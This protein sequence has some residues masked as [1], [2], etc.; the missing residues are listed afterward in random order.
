MTIVAPEQL[1]VASLNATFETAHPEKIVEWAASHF[2]DELVMSSSFGEQAAVLLHMATRLKPDIRIIFVDTGYLFPETYAFM[3]ALRH[4]FNLNVW[5][6]RT[7]NDPIVWLSV[8]GEPDPRQRNNID[9]C[10]AANKN[11][12]F[13]RAFQQL[14]PRAWLRGTRRDQSETRKDFA[15]IH[16]AK[17][18]DCYAISPLLN[19]TQRDVHAYMKQHDLP[20]HPL[21]EKGYPSIGCNPLSCTMNVLPGEDPRSGR[22]AG[23]QKTECGINLTDSMDSA[24]L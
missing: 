23:K 2:A 4:R 17:R 22:W 1:D 8:N 10:C 7:R 15:F 20:Y 19:W 5:T 9:A 16:W 18:Y 6:F 13:N 14:R 24:K 11:E 12:P 3:E 21:V